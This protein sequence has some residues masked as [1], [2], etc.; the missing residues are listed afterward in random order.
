M[1]ARS[2]SCWELGGGTYTLAVDN[3]GNHWEWALHVED[4]GCHVETLTYDP[5]LDPGT[6]N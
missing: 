4:N 3:G 1:S 2:T 6:A 5:E